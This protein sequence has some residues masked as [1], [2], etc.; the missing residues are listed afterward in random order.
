MVRSSL[1]R[2][3]AT[4]GVLLGLVAGCD[5]QQ[6]MDP[7]NK[8]NTEHFSIAIT[9]DRDSV[10]VG[11][12]VALN[13]TVLD[14]RGA[15]RTD[16]AIRW[17]SLTPNVASVDG[18]G[19]VT[20]IAVGDARIVATV[21]QGAQVAADTATVLVQAGQVFLTIVP[22]MAEITLGD[23]VQLEATLLAPTGSVRGL[24]AQWSTSDE[25]I[26][27][28]TE[29]GIVVSL[30]PGDVTFTAVVNGLTA[31]AQARVIQN[32][33]TSI[34]VTPANSGLNPGE[35]VQ[36]TAWVRDS[37]GKLIR[38]ANVRWSSSASEVAA[39]TMDGLVIARQKGAAFITA[40]IDNR[41]ASASVN[42]FAVPAAGVTITAPS[43]TVPVGGRMQAVATARDADGNILT[44]RQVA[45][46]S[47][48]P[49]VAQVASDGTISG[50]TI[51][52][53]TINA[54]I[55]GQIGTLPISVV[56]SAPAS[57]AIVP[58]SAT[59]SL[60]KTAQ[61]IAEVRD[62][63]GNVLP[64]QPISW[65]S[66]NSAIAT[67]SSNGLVTGVGAGTANI[68]ATS[69]SFSTT[70]SVTVI[71][72]AVS[73]VA[74][75]PSAA[76]LQIG[77]TQ[78]LS[79]VVTSNGNVVPNAA[80]SWSSSNPAVISVSSAGLATGVSPGSATVTATSSGASG[81]ASLTV[82]APAPAQVATVTVT[83]NS[84]SIAVGQSTQATATAR[85]ANGNV[86]TGRTV[87]WSSDDLILASVSAT[88]LVTAIAAGSPLI[89]AKV[90]GV[91]GWATLT[92]TAPAPLPVY[93]VQLTLNPTSIT[94]GQ[95]SAS[96]V[97]LRDSLGTVLTGRTIGWSSSK[98]N[99]AS[100]GLGGVVTGIAAGAAT[101]TA[102]SAGKS[103][104]A[105][106]TVA[107][108]TTIPSVATV[109]VTA[110][111]TNLTPG[112][113]TQAT[114]V[115]KD[116]A[117][118]VL[119]GQTI[120]WA[121][122]NAAAATVSA[123]GLVS[124]VAAGSTTIIATA[125]GKTGSM[126]INV[127]A[128]ATASVVVSAPSSSVAVG[129]TMQ[130]SAVVKDASG[131]AIP[132]ALVFWS[133]S[134]ASVA[135]VSLTGVITGVSVG[136]ANITASNSGKSGSVAVTVTA[137][138]PPPP[139]GSVPSITPA[140]P[141]ASVNIGMPT[142]T[143]TLLV[144]AGGNLQAALDSAKRGDEIVLQAGATFT[145]NFELKTKPGTTAN[146]WIV[147]RSS[148]LAQLPPLGQ[149]ID[150]ALHAS[151]MPK[152]VT[153]NVLPAIQTAYSQSGNNGWR[154]V[155]LEIAV[156]PGAAIAPNIQ[157]GI[158][159][160][161]Q[162][163]QSE[164]TV[165]KLPYNLILD[166]SYVHGQSN[167]NVK[168]CVALNSGAAAIIGSQLLEC[169]GKGFDSQAAAGWNGTGPFLIE[170]NRLEAAGE[171]IM[172]GGSIA[173]ISGLVASDIVIRHNYLT[174]PLSWKGVFT[175]KN[176]FE[177]KNAQRVLFE[178][179]ALD[180]HW[181]DAQQGPAVVL[182]TADNPC[183]WCIVQDVTFR[184]N[185]L[186]NVSD[187][188]NI[189]SHY[190]NAQ[191]MR[192]VQISQTLVTNLGSAA[193]G[194]YGRAFL[195][196]DDVNDLWIEQTTA[197]ARQNYVMFVGTGTLAKQ[198]FTFRNNIGGGALYNW[199]SSSGQGD[200]ASKASLVSGYL[201]AGNG[202]IGGVPTTT[203]PTGSKT[204]S[205]LSAVSFVNPVWPSGNW[206]LGSSSSF[207]GS[208]VDYN[209]LQAKLLNVR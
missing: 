65:S 167:T 76:Q 140:L 177:L 198:R 111:A 188:F 133:S 42:V 18:V 205:S 119:G 126:V 47:S 150:P 54:I 146:G 58:A 26:A 158:V 95:T 60:G 37:R 143:R 139:T 161:G 82:S 90:D 83:F 173:P 100:V 66:G 68:T 75:S 191:P 194:G 203:V 108:S 130:A 73:S 87:V 97:T 48:N 200:A 13:A 80:V 50:L 93:S 127:A 144:N 28:I 122:S 117:G 156:A 11:A 112:Q 195:L 96:T 23:S 207:N 105:G 179:N 131:N 67:V 17:S 55:D 174:R 204:V 56:G 2:S 178:E 170:N 114:A 115:A 1:T 32:V 180:N 15:A 116:S 38:N 175:V 110:A 103:G 70:A 155:G 209:T 152:I 59:I 164:N 5:Q 157:Q 125:G 138:Q 197:V 41:K 184:W 154:L 187:A 199:F 106:L 190:G 147:V 123:N 172:F 25:T 98:P 78:Q 64:G 189:F 201:I 27:P 132:G 72:A 208:G 159:L 44:A 3:I 8:P 168:R 181:V 46:S 202:F 120:A 183:T 149:R 20:G 124:A 9:P 12:T 169:H 129:Q 165:A 171:V 79:A 88:G 39:V 196:Q 121:T 92:V 69:G 176:L 186:D 84:Q 4:L 148:A 137:P 113:T 16:Q 29:D 34:S 109:T 141:Q 85:D 81:S 107:G 192:R 99:V 35:S 102:T 135:A 36:L 49:S 57:I 193:V 24:N 77:G 19:L 74:V 89:V 14:A 128:P 21:G 206:A 62:Q 22:G 31:T 30:Q 145:G 162:G 45:W 33:P 142:S 163:D 6:S 10:D 101:I 104:N 160:F 118:N 40:T 53:T 52:N 151:L 7:G 51:G 91:P 153:P 71:S 61:L 185:H 63:G 136:T 43:N 94:A 166:R 134:N 86:L 182:G